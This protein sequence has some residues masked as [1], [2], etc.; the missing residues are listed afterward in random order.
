MATAAIPADKLTTAEEFRLLPD[1][2]VPMELVRGRIVTMNVP[3]PRH[4]YYCSLVV[5]VVAPF[6]RQ[7]DRGRVLCN[8]SGVIT[9]RNPDTVRGADV[10][11][12]SYDR[13]PRGPIPAGYLAV[14]P[15]VVWEVRS[16]TDRWSEVLAKVAEY[17][18]AGVQVVC[19]HDMQT[20]TLTIHRPD[21]PPQVLRS[22]DELVL[23]EIHAD[24]RVPIR[25]FFE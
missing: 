10:S 24:F 6:V 7:Y 5:E 4:G 15:N 25:R 2:G 16:P 13:L 17:L 20:E 3:A 9:E 19:V 12:Y 21:Q 14:V 11:Y 22:D 23:P 1:D 8:D 18:S